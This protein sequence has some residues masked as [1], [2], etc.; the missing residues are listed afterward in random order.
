MAI[1]TNRK[2]NT[3]LNEELQQLGAGV[4]S[5]DLAF[6]ASKRLDESAF[7]GNLMG[8][9]AKKEDALDG[10]FVTD[11]LLDRVDALNIE[12]VSDDDL[13]ALIDGLKAKELPEGEEINNKAEAV[14]FKLVNE[15]KLREL[16]ADEVTEFLL[17]KLEAIDLETVEDEDLLDIVNGLLEKNEPSEE[18]QARSEAFVQTVFDEAVKRGKALVIKKTGGGMMKRAQAGFK[19]VDG[20]IKRVS[21]GELKKKQRKRKMEYKTGGRAKKKKYL[22]KRGRRLQMRRKARGL[23]ADDQSKNMETELRELLNLDNVAEN[24]ET[25]EV[26]KYDETIER[27]GNIFE[28]ISERFESEAV[29]TVLD[30]CWE[31][32]DQGLF[33]SDEDFEAVVKP[34]LA[35]I[36]R[37]LEEIESGN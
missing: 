31:R 13:A 25:V 4:N 19:T 30:E 21:A 34:A 29:D 33:E 15:M 10:R 7:C 35:I 3:D 8:M 37:C 32:I 1:I 14:A 16:D 6:L 28:L 22:A 26:T 36:K 18:L 5:N 9:A 27:I 23:A 2:V 20:Q 12:D 17:N 11:E 24:A